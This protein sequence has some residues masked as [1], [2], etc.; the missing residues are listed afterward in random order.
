MKLE[1]RNPK[2]IQNDENKETT[3]LQT[4]RIEFGVSDFPTLNLFDREF[5]SNFDIRISDLSFWGLI[6]VSCFEFRILKGI[7]CGYVWQADFS[8]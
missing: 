6:R 3:M 7:K 4:G 5:V 8:N 1:I 2:Q